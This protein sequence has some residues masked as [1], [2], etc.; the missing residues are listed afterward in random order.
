[1]TPPWV[2]QLTPPHDDD[3]P[4][5]PAPTMLDAASQTSTPSPLWGSSP[6]L[7]RE[8]VDIFEELPQAIFY[9]ERV[10]ESIDVQPSNCN[11]CG[12]AFISG[13]LRLGYS[14]DLGF[15]RAFR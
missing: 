1:M 4:G 9:V 11:A 2:T 8:G 14:T 3:F 13:Q 6:I 7:P 5:S 12:I 10:Q 15:S